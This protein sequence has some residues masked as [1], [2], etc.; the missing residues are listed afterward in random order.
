[1][2]LKLFK[3]L[4]ILFLGF[5]GLKNTNAQV[6]NTNALDLIG[7]PYN[8]PE[9]LDVLYRYD[10]SK[11]KEL[12]NPAANSYVVECP[13]GGFAM[14]FDINFTLKSIRLFDSGYSYKKCNLQAPYNVGLAMHIDTV[15]LN[16]LLFHHDQYA[17][18]KLF[19][20][21][22]NSRVELYFKDDYVE[23]IKITATA[24]FLNQSNVENASFW[25]FR[26]IPDG[27]CVTGTCTNDSGFMDWGNGMLQ[28]KGSWSYG[29]PHGEGMYRDSFGNLY[30]GQFK[31]GFMWG[32]GTLI[33]GTEQ[34]EG[35]MVMGE[36]TGMGRSVYTNGSIY[37]G[38][39][40]KDII[41]GRG[42]LE[43]NK[44]FYYEGDFNNGQY[45]GFGKLGNQEGYYEGEFVKGKPHGRGVQFAYDSEKKLEGKWKNGLKHGIFQLTS[46]VTKMQMLRFE[47]DIE[48]PMK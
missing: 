34:Y 18:F 2:K 36:K 5:V 6:L 29:F 35:D 13:D 48:V 44:N 38:Q 1:M 37:E 3:L 8:S 28:Y 14:E 19:G 41:Q 25:K 43:I 47:N 23:M 45:H 4:F 31:L 39:W 9:I 30:K 40:R 27:E 26:L 42:R 21:F 46:P 16:N 15:H 33:R 32:K 20:D 22:E 7:K 11:N 12:L 10:M 24:E 17:E